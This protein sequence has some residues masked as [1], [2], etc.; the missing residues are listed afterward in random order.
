MD[1][2]Y[3]EDVEST[4]RLVFLGISQWSGEN[5]YDMLTGQ[6]LSFANYWISDLTRLDPADQLVLSDIRR[7]MLDR[8]YHIKYSPN[9][10]KMKDLLQ[11]LQYN[12]SQL[13]PGD[14]IDVIIQYYWTNFPKDPTAFIQPP[15]NE[16]LY[17]V[18]GINTDNM[19]AYLYDSTNQTTTYYTGVTYHGRKID[20]RCVSCAISSAPYV[21]LTW[22][23][24]LPNGAYGNCSHYNLTQAARLHLGKTM[25]TQNIRNDNIVIRVLNAARAKIESFK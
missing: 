10:A 14:L 15:L 17:E 22:H 2:L 21:E 12:C 5:Y 18:S 16:V 1:D 9:V 24:N 8:H 20:V 13:I 6:N 19:V 11:S 23:V 4:I 7:K 3:G 25:L